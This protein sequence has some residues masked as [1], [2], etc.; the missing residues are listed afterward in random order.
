MASANIKTKAWP[1]ITFAN[2]RQVGT[3]NGKKSVE[4]KTH[5][6]NRQRGHSHDRTTR[7]EVERSLVDNDL[8]LSAHSSDKHFHSP[9]PLRIK[10][11][12][13][14]YKAALR[15]DGIYIHDCVPVE[16]WPGGINVRV[17][18]SQSTLTKMAKTVSQ[19]SVESASKIS[20]QVLVA[21][22]QNHASS[23]RA[24]NN[25]QVDTTVPDW[26]TTNHVIAGDDVVIYQYKYHASMKPVVTCS[27]IN[28]RM[29][30][31]QLQTQ[32]PSPYHFVWNKNVKETPDE[33]KGLLC[34]T[35]NA[36]WSIIEAYDDKAVAVKLLPEGDTMRL[37]IL[38][39]WELG[40]PV[41][42]VNGELV[43]VMMNPRSMPIA[44]S[45]ERLVQM[46]P[47]GPD[48]IRLPE[49]DQVRAGKLIKKIKSKKRHFL[50]NDKSIPNEPLPEKVPV[51]Y[52]LDKPDLRKSPGVDQEKKFCVPLWK[53][54]P[55]K[56]D[57]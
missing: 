55:A 3:S 21:S 41:Q 52:V 31:V 48:V 22:T 1:V 40:Y 27:N 15:C 29:T 5:D 8:T 54:R 14:K 32:F 39:L 9:T 10:I 24:N 13:A 35:R 38:N 4:V 44:S 34:Y 17:R 20:R 53:K 56:E 16:R 12:K 47:S 6:V 57:W 50:L 45:G 30:L 49:Y 37:T 19:R 46:D 26:T 51:V 7:V 36:I 11:S 43:G 25:N 2:K 28:Q 42:Q 23:N 33:L 18:D